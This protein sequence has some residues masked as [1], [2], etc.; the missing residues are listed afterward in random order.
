ME[1]RRSI[2]TWL[3]DAPAEEVLAWADAEFGA[4]AVI[5]SSFGVEDVV[6]SFLDDREG[7]VLV[8]RGLPGAKGIYDRLVTAVDEAARARRAA[9]T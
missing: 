9:A 4:R 3:A 7:G 2:P 5:A 8:M 1:G 6:L